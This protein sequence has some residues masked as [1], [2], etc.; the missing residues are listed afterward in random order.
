MSDHVSRFNPYDFPLS[1][2]SLPGS[3][4]VGE[5]PQDAASLSPLQPPSAPLAASALSTL[6]AVAAAEEL[7]HSTVNPHFVTPAEPSENPRSP[8]LS[9][10]TPNDDNDRA[11]DDA[12]VSIDDGDADDGEAEDNVAVA[13]QSEE[14]K[15]LHHYLPG[16]P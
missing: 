9:D 8:A 3:S 13:G 15:A 12:K 16:G 10:A 7:E 4:L 14:G 11:S 6:T 1:P 5:E 2:A